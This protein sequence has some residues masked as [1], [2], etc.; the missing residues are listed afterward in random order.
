MFGLD[1]AIREIRELHEHD[2]EMEEIT[3][4]LEKSNQLKKRIDLLCEFGAKLALKRLVNKLDC[5]DD[6]IDAIELGEEVK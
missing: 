3:E 2:K 5:F 1:E 4:K 6:L